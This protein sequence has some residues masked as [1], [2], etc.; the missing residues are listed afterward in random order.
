MKDI[1]DAETDF[2]SEDENSV[3]QKSPKNTISFDKPQIDYSKIDDHHGHKDVW[4]VYKEIK[5]LSD[6][7]FLAVHRKF[8]FEVTIREIKT[9]KHKFNQIDHELDT[10]KHTNHPHM[11]KVLDYF[12]S[13]H[14]DHV[15]LVTEFCKG[16]SL[17]HRIKNHK[18]TEIEIATVIR[19]IL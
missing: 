17:K 13:K 1:C 18:L 16:G 15:Y 2:S 19:S 4:D 6:H 14:K 3:K 12:W 8:K 9:Q 10:L 5:K 7:L 11:A